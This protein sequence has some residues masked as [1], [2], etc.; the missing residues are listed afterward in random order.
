MQTL[1]LEALTQNVQGWNETFTAGTTLVLATG[2]YDAN[3]SPQDAGRANRAKA[4][5]Q[6][7]QFGE[8]TPH[9]VYVTSK[10][11]A[12]TSLLATI[13]PN[14]VG[15]SLCVLVGTAFCSNNG[16]QPLP[17]FQQIPLHPGYIISA[18][19]RYDASKKIQAPEVL[20]WK[21]VF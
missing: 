14:G 17:N 5:R 7:Q 8:L 10:V 20:A 4:E 19:Q 13:T 1:T 3:A 16:E 12:D 21:A 6:L 18:G 15:F 9:M 2:A 11:P